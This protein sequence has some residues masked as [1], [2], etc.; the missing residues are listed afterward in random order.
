M[1]EQ[2]QINS[3]INQ[4]YKYGFTTDIAVESFP[5][6]LNDQIIHLICDK[7]KE[8]LFLREIRLRAYK[9]WTLMDSPVWPDLDYPK[10]DYSDIL[11]YSKPALKGQANNDKAIVDTFEKLGVALNEKE[12]EKNIAVDIV[13]DSVSIGT[14]FYK[15]LEKHGVIFCPIM[16]AVERYPE[17][18][19]SFLGRVVP[20]GDNFFAALNTAVFSDGSFCF[21]PKGVV[22]PME[23]STYFRMNN[24][25]SGQFERTLI[26]VEEEGSVSYLEG[27]TAPMHSN[28]Q[29]H[30]AIVELIVFDKATIKYS[31]VQN[32]FSGD[33]NGVGG[34]YNLVTKRALCLG[35]S[36][37]V[38]WTQVETGSAITCKYPSCVLMG[39]SSVG[40]FYSVALTSNYQQADTG[41]KMIHFGSNTKSRIVSKGI[42]AVHSKNTYRGLV[43]IGSKADN[44]RNYSQCDSLLIGDHSKSNTYPYL[45]VQNPTARVEHE[46]STSRLQEE[47]I[48]FLLQRGISFEKGVALMING[49]CREVFNELPLEFAAE[50]DQLLSLKLEGSVG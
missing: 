3:I 41:T 15:K 20:A 6:G 47:Q 29:L 35:E 5:K 28:N 30:A 37:K 18:V 2:N 43:K 12:S 32:W 34:V 13:F 7:R 9:K 45:C 44:C 11:Y 49:F 46:A 22:C 40:E 25:E 19:K 31:T 26:I 33:A 23:L 50:A 4:P 36:S 39:N 1:A 10:I 17:L 14:T 38:S 42:S 24:K 27:C 48:F 21:I 16:Q 8:P